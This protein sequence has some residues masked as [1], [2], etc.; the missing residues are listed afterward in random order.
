MHGIGVSAEVTA[1]SADELSLAE[2]E[3]VELE[4]DAAAK[5]ASAPDAPEAVRDRNGPEGGP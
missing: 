1:S 3:V 4:L 2:E 5:D